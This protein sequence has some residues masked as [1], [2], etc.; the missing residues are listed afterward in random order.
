MGRNAT[1]GALGDLVASFVE[2]WNA[3]DVERVA[4]HYAADYQGTDIGFAASQRGPENL[5]AYVQNYL[6]AFPDL[7]LRPDETVVEGNCVAMLWTASGTHSGAFM[8]IPP[9]GRHVTV[10]GASFIEVR[11]GLVTR[12]RAIW[13]LAGM[14]RAIG[15]LPE[16]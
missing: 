8:G 15:L 16:L 14:L 2:A 1:E 5:R 3:H 6:Q 13:D 9:T 4:A 11:H 12:A 7:T 10:Q